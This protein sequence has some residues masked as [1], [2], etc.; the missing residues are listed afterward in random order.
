MQEDVEAVLER[1]TVL[2]KFLDRLNYRTLRQIY[3]I[4]NN[5]LSSIDRFLSSNE[6]SLHNM[7]TTLL[8]S[9]SLLA[10]TFYQTSIVDYLRSGG[11]TE[12]EFKEEIERAYLKGMN[13]RELIVQKTI[14]TISRASE[15]FKVKEEVNNRWQNLYYRTSPEIK[16]E[17]NIRQDLSLVLSK[18]DEYNKIYKTNISELEDYQNQKDLISQVTNLSYEAIDLA[19]KA[20]MTLHEL[21][22]ICINPLVM[23]FEDEIS[24]A[25]KIIAQIQIGDNKSK[26]KLSEDEIGKLCDVL[27]WGLDDINNYDELT[28]LGKELRNEFASLLSDFLV[29]LVDIDLGI[30]EL[31]SFQLERAE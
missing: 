12:R 31:E 4:M 26:D 10:R 20:Q 15:L 18:Q 28:I 8:S 21:L 23:I 16:T 5:L 22:D 17:Q 2:G 29:Y 3:T 13:E 19:D 7:R 14:N 9:M 27:S 6:D 30:Q 24:S 11:K 25:E 1:Q